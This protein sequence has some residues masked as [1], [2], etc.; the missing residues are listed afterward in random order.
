MVDDQPENVVLVTAK[1]VDDLFAA[2]EGDVESYCSQVTPGEGRLLH[3]IAAHEDKI[4]GR[5]MMAFY[6]AA[7]V[8]QVMAEEI[9]YIAHAC[10]TDIIAHCDEVPPGE[11]RILGCLEVNADELSDACIDAVS[12]DAD[13]EQEP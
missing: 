8:L 6:N 2:C 7:A 12:R 1:L 10:E 11:G 13:A 4:S 9:A 3:C 5:C